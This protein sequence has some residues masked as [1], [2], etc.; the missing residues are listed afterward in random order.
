MNKYRR[1]G[2]ASER[3]WKAGLPNN[4]DLDLFIEQILNEAHRLDFQ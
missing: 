2:V 1:D 3:D 4:T